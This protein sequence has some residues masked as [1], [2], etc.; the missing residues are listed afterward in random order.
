MKAIPAIHGAAMMTREVHSDHRG[1]FSELY[2]NGSI[3]AVAFVQQNVSHSDRGVL[4][5]M[6]F[7]TTKPQAKLITCLLGRIHDVL[8]DLRRE[9]PTFGQGYAVELDHAEGQCLYAPA[10]V[11]HGFLVLSEIALVQYNCS[12]FHDPKGDAGVRWDSPGLRSLFPSHI[13]PTMSARDRQ[14]PTVADFLKR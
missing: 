11:A 14:L 6:H 7:Q 2:R 13:D 9:S 4:R 10:G 8:F 5:G 3:P 1:Y 12:T